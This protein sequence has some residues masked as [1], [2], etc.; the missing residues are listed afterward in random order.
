M[1]QELYDHVSKLD[2]DCKIIE[3]YGITECG[4]IVTL[5]RPDFPHDKGV[6]KPVMGVELCVID[7][8]THEPLD[9]NQE[10]EICIRGP[11]VFKGYLDPQPSPFLYI[12]EKSWY[13][14]GD[15]GHLDQEGNLFLSGRLE[16]FIK[17][18]G[19]T[20]SLSNLEQEI[21]QIAIEKK[22][23]EVIN[24][25]PP[26]ALSIREQHSDRPQIILFTTF[27]V[28]KDEINSILK[29]NGFR[30]L[31]K[32]AEVRRLEQIPLTGTGKT[33]YRLLDNMNLSHF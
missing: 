23:S 13:R 4:P 18:G 3:G 27:D 19:E 5:M 25:V 11:G 21:V 33:H 20:I 26:L 14:S 6:G 2:L 7:I 8:E 15:K 24:G 29:K 9:V 22:W 12:K 16:R 31:V 30:R 10:G 32:I 28:S 17:I 1:P